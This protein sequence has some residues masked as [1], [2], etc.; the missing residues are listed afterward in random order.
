MQLLCL[1][2]LALMGEA[3]T[4][5]V[6]ETPGGILPGDEAR[7]LL[8]WELPIGTVTNPRPRSRGLR[9]LAHPD[10]PRVIRRWTPGF[11]TL[12][13]NHI[14]DAGTAGL[15]DTI[16]TLSRMGFATVGAG[17]TMAEI[18]QPR[19][20]ET[21]QGRLAIVNW[22]FPETHPDW[23]CVPGPCCWPGYEKAERVMHDLKRTSDWVLL[24]VH[25]SDEDFAYPRP[26]DREIARRLVEMG[27][28]LI[29]GHHPHVVRGMEMIG[30]CPVF[31]SLGNFF[32]SD[33]PD[34]QGGWLVRQA[35]KNRIGLG[36]RLSFRLGRMPEYGLVSFWRLRNRV[37]LD[38][39]YRA[40]R[41]LEYI[42]QPLRQWRGLEYAEWH[43]K[44]HAAFFRRGYL[45]HFGL[46]T[47]GW[48]DLKRGLSKRLRRIL[49]S[50]PGENVGNVQR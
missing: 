1:G 37:V 38:P 40:A 24:V 13:T 25:W 22:V 20:W 3:A 2:D 32:F 44:E 11:A 43:V 5:Q 31:Y 6:W 35:P 49:R 12:A 14:L 17:R 15:A 48:G 21:S 34:G 16:E 30:S 10:S 29:I 27:V 4:K 23:L 19:F 36:V 28:D 7:I 8:N 45:W 33:I 26:E 18:G 42:S 46:W 39:I 50:D 47:M 9:F 41:N